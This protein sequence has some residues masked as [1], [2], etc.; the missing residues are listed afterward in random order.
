[1]RRHFL[2]MLVGLV[3]GPAPGLA[4]DLTKIER[5]I[6][7][8]PKYLSAKPLYGLLV[9][10]PKAETSA[11][12]VIDK[13]GPSSAPYD[14]L[15]FDRAG[16]GDLTLQAHKFTAAKEEA[17]RSKFEIGDFTDLSTGEKHTDLSIS[18]DKGPAPN[19]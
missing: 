15:Y 4:I 5:K 13:S 9:F 12:F 7:K 17:G 19:V 14:V 11:W 6:A 3:L 1:M 18:V 16:H 10:G 2:L 8:E